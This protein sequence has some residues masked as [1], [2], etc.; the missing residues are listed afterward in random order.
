MMRRYLVLASALALLIRP[1]NLKA[2]E[3]L[4]LPLP[5]QVSA[6]ITVPSDGHTVISIGTTGGPDRREK[7]RKDLPAHPWAH[8]PGAGALSVGDG[9]ARVLAPARREAGALNCTVHLRGAS[10]PFQIQL[11]PPPPGLYAEVNV[12][13][14]FAGGPPVQL[15]PFVIMPG[16]EILTPQTVRASTSGGRLVRTPQGSLT[17]HLPDEK[18][19]RALVVV[20][21]DGQRH[22]AVF[23]PVVARTMLPIRTKRRVAVEVRVAGRAFGPLAAPRGRVEMPLEVPV[24]VTRAAVRATDR[25]GNVTEVPLDLR[26]PTRSRIAA[27]SVRKIVGAGEGGM[28]VIAVAG[29]TGGP[30]SESSRPTARP[31]RGETGEPVRQGPGL[32]TV[33][34]HAPGTVGDDEI[35]IRVDGDLSAGE[36]VMKMRIT[37]ER[38]LAAAQV[39]VSPPP[40]AWRLGVQILGG[41]SHNGGTMSTPRMTAGVGVRT[42]VGPLQLG[43]G[44]GIDWL[45]Y[46]DRTEL[47]VAG[48]DRVIERRVNILS[49]P[50]VLLARYP[51]SP[52]WGV[53]LAGGPSLTSAAA[54]SDPAFQ[55]QET[56]F[57]LVPGGRVEIAGDVRVGP[58]E[59]ALTARYGTARVAEGPIRGEIDG[60][61]VLLGYQWWF[62]DLGGSSD[63]PTAP[64]R[65]D[66]VEKFKPRYDGRRYSTH[67]RFN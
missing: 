18:V 55:P 9:V 13:Q 7:E 46:E 63:G 58:G 47:R 54:T 45:H 39:D 31:T 61:S 60:F 57:A 12:A 42:G 24:G 37:G 20:L 50:L 36:V 17:L 8:C 19:P 10:A 52:R 56:F 6:P 34:Y 25:L 28:L 62:A 15:R 22:G 43:I 51:I 66:R 30:A 23:V 49:F 16:G 3:Q 53:S 59:V 4:P 67:A 1:A 65:I 41:F 29:P 27:V 40:S 5:L 44:T 2:L 48:A 26:T 64:T 21:T 35:T 33:A 32:W 11:T 14:P 38:L